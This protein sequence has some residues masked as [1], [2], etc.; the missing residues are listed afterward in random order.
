M[1][2]DGTDSENHDHLQPVVGPCQVG[3]C[4]THGQTL[5]RQVLQLDKRLGSIDEFLLAQSQ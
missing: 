5:P 1:K 4:G 2:H 3:W